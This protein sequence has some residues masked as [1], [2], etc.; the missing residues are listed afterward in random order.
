MHGLRTAQRVQQAL[1][2]LHTAYM[3]HVLRDHQH[4]QT[5]WDGVHRST[6]SSCR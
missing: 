3:S 2:A 6:P 5:V 1:Q 4:S